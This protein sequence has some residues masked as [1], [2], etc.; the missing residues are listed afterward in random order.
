MDIDAPLRGG[1][2]ERAAKV[3]QRVYGKKEPTKGPN[4]AA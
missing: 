4:K 3:V 2:D 1:D